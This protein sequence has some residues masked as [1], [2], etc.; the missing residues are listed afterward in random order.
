M[1]RNLV[2]QQKA[3]W[4]KVTSVNGTSRICQ[5]PFYLISQ[6]IIQSFRTVVTLTGDLDLWTPLHQSSHPVPDDASVEACMGAIQWWNYIPGE[7][8]SE[9][10]QALFATFHTHSMG[11]CSKLEALAITNG[12]WSKKAIYWSIINHT[13]LAFTQVQIRLQHSASSG[14]SWVACWKKNPYQQ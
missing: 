8:K 9:S 13:V 12:L 4:F 1:I 7:R 6:A 3:A 5:L 14:C 2:N 11:A 10:H